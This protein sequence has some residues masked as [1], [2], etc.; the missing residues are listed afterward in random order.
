LEEGETGDGTLAERFKSY[1]TLSLKG[2]W[3]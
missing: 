3:F 1:I 2:L